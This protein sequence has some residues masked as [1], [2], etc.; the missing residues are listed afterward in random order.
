MQFKKNSAIQ[1][2]G[3]SSRETETITIYCGKDNAIA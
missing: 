1:Q 3:L 2:S